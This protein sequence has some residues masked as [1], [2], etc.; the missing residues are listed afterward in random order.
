MSQETTTDP[1]ET[2]DL[3]EAKDIITEV[4]SDMGSNQMEKSEKEEMA[5]ARS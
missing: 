2:A 3:N 1:Q 5:I 4:G